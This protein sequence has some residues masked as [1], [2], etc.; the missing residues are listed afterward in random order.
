MVRKPPPGLVQPPENPFLRFYRSLFFVLNS[1]RGIFFQ[2]TLFILILIF[3]LIV[4]GR[5]HSNR[6][7]NVFLDFLFRSRPAPVADPD[8]VFIEIA[9]DGIQQIGR[10]PW[11]REYH[12]ALVQVL[13]EWKAKSIVFD[14]IFSEPSDNYNDDVFTEALKTTD[15]IYFPVV[16]EPSKQGPEIW[17]HSLPQFEKYAKGTGHI[18][19]TPDADGTLRRIHP[20]LESD[21]ESHPHLSL[22]VAYDALGRPVP[23]PEQLKLP[24]DDRGDFLINWQNTWQKSFKHYSYLEILRSYDQ[25]EKGNQGKYSPEDFKGKICL[26]GLTATGHADIKANPLE[27]NYPALGVHANLINSI[28]TQKFVRP[29]GKIDNYLFLGAV[30]LLAALLFI[31]FRATLAVTGLVLMEIG[32]FLFSFHAFSK[33]GIWFYVTTPLALVLTLFIFSAVYGYVMANRERIYLFRLATRDGLTGALVIRH[34]K[35]I[36]S[37]AIR[38]AAKL[39]QPLSVVMLDIDFFKKI[40]DQHGHQAGDMVLRQVAQSLQTYVRYGKQYQVSDQ[41]GRYG[42]EEFIILLPNTKLTEAAAVVAERVRKGIES[43]VFQWGGNN[44]PVTV[45]LGVSAWKEG[46]TDIQLVIGRADAALYRAKGEGRNRVCM[47]F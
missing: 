19:I 13:T 29:A 45:S 5:L 20:Y 15:H 23:S 26:I 39:K 35:V 11:P 42:G 43:S 40:N 17:V 24:L 9:E 37:Q 14:V 18:N 25:I 1:F 10:W 47:E 30:W 21:G 8:I 16:R 36:L 31:P 6:I 32:I 22:R 3:H 33:W 4:A 46:E 38:E 34:F 12:A 27:A 28:L 2:I 7:E 44:I 41:I